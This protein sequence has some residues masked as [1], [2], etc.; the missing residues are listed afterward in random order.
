MEFVNSPVDGLAEMPK[1]SNT[2]SETC[3]APPLSSSVTF[4]VST[5][6]SER[7]GSESVDCLAIACNICIVIWVIL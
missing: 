1:P 5:S 7:Y 6:S 3:E 4:P 2:S